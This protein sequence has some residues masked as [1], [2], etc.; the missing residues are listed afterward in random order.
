MNNA[1]YLDWI[2]DLTS[3]DFH[4]QRSMKEMTMCYINEAL[5]VQDLDLTWELNADGWMQVDVHRNRDDDEQDY[6][7]IFSAKILY[8]NEIL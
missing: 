5:E 6:D 3:S 1:R 8:E 7:R 2:D 4:R